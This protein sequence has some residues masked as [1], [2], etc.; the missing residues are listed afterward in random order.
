MDQVQPLFYSFTAL[1]FN[2]GCLEDPVAFSAT[3]IV[4]S[5][6]LKVN[7]GNDLMYM[8]A[9]LP[10]VYLPTQIF[11]TF[12]IMDVLE[13]WFYITFQEVEKLQKL[14]ITANANKWC[15]LALCNM[16]AQMISS[17][18]DGFCKQ[19]V[20]GSNSYLTEYQQQDPSQAAQH[21]YFLIMSVK[22]NY[23]NM[24]NAYPLICYKIH[25]QDKIFLTVVPV[26]QI[27]KK[28]MGS[29]QDPLIFSQARS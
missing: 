14:S 22:V 7:L 24:H 6:Y 12:N 25:S 3:S 8:R 13:K 9:R 16:T 21:V 17:R 29:I 27:F 26:S 15:S 23:N 11:F 2:P 5:S 10:M 4:P 20:L 28:V 19:P 18:A 1:L